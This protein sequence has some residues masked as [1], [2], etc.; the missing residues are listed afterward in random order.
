[1][2][3]IVK[4]AIPW[5]LLA[6]GLCVGVFVGNFSSI[7]IVPQPQYLAETHGFHFLTVDDKSKFCTNGC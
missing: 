2:N 6:T 5:V 3:R 7:K 1:M 4:S